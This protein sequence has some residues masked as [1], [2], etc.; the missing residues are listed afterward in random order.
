V[1]VQGHVD[2]A[3]AI[4]ADKPGMKFRMHIS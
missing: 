2:S 3:C 4:R 1:S